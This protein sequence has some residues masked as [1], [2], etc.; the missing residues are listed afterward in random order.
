MVDDYPAALEKI[1]HR[2]SGFAINISIYIKILLGCKVCVAPLSCVWLKI[3]DEG[4][5]FEKAGIK[6]TD[7]TIE[8][9]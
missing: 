5:S 1:G 3:G 8:K 6:R 2:C 4:A 7:G 9:Q